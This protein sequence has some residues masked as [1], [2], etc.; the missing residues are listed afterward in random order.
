LL[1]YLEPAAIDLGFREVRI[2]SLLALAAIVVIYEI[3]VRRAPRHGID[4]ATASSLIVWAIAL[5]LTSAHLFDVLV[6]TPELLR[7]NPWELFRLWGGL[8]SWGGIVGGLTGLYVV[9]RRRGM[10]SD[11]LLRFFDCVMFALPAGLAV[12]RLGCA[13]EH[14]HMGFLSTSFFAVAAPEGP[15]FDLGLLEFLYCSLQAGLFFALGRRPRPDGFWTLLFFVSY[16]PVR[17]ALDALRTG[18]ARYAELTPAQWL[19]AATAIVGVALFARLIWRTRGKP[20]A[21]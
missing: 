3:V 15:R 5:G 14:D 20:A 2:F 18:D 6:Y 11:H 9:A 19:S 16:S 12:G 1:P 10:A 8:S 13:F 21:A 4:S 7:E 17:F